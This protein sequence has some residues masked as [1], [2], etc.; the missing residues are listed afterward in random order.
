[1]IRLCFAEM[2]GSGSQPDHLVLDGE[3]VPHLKAKK[4]PDEKMKIDGLSHEADGAPH[5]V[6]D[7]GAA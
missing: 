4:N 7:Q 1:M 5:M 6:C 3:R 2:Q